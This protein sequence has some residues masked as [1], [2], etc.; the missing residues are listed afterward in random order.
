MKKPYDARNCQSLCGYGR[1]VHRRSG[2]ICK[3]CSFG[4]GSS[5]DPS[6]WRQLTVEHI[7]PASRGGKL[8]DIKKA[9]ETRFPDIVPDVLNDRANSIDRE[10]TITAC[11]FCNSATSRWPGKCNLSNVILH[12]QGNWNWVLR[13]V[14]LA[15]KREFNDKKQGIKWKLGSVNRLFKED[16][17]PELNRAR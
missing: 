1:E 11:H 3:Y 15:I 17:G 4:K 5:L 2:G 14:I 9:L 10:N 6:L 13:E 12:T 8:S 7:I 16:I